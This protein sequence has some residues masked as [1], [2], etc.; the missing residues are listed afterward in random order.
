MQYLL[1][2]VNVSHGCDAALTSHAHPKAVQSN[3]KASPL[4]GPLSETPVTSTPSSTHSNL[5]SSFK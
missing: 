2:N 5:S 4:W 3:S 1:V